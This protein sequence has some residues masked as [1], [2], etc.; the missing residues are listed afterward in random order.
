MHQKSAHGI[1]PKKKSPNLSEVDKST[2]IG[3]SK[4]FENFRVNECSQCGYQAHTK[5][6]LSEHIL[7]IHSGYK[8]YFFS[9]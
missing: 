5:R 8:Y 7:R 3:F 2:Q 1:E 4:P 6:T 9:L